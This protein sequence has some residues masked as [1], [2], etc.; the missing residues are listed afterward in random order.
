M[1]SGHGSVEQ[2]AAGLATVLKDYRAGD[3]LTAPSADS[4]LEWLDQFDSLENEKIAFLVEL[5][6]IFGKSYYS[7][8]RVKG[9]LRGLASNMKFVG[10]NPKEF[11]QSVNVLTIQRRGSSQSELVAILAEQVKAVCGVDLASRESEHAIYLDDAIFSGNHVVNDVTA[12][13]ETACLPKRLSVVALDVAT[14]GWYS[15]RERLKERMGF[16][17]VVSGFTWAENRSNFG[18]AVDVCRLRAFPTDAMSQ[19]FLKDRL[20][21]GQPSLLRGAAD[22]SSKL[23]TDESRRNLVESMFWNAG[24]KCIELCSLLSS[25]VRPLGY[26]SAKGKNKLGFGSLYASYRNCPN[27]APVA[28]W[29]GDPWIP[30]LPRR[31]N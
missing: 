3:G 14:S 17:P 15:L 4:V 29:A 16:E 8:E 28:L 21:G 27:N 19:R 9:S 13:L 22:N 12:W 11:W 6:A 5:T 2:A 26:C 18:S 30:L 25:N 1:S 23:F 24:L 7:L 31:T 20:D 10:A